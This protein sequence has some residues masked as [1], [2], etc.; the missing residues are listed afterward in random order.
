MSQRA[1]FVDSDV[2][3]NVD[4]GYAYH[5]SESEFLKGFVDL[6]RAAFAQRCLLLMV[7]N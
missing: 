4:A 3:M 6:S 1:I 7:T 5:A 2:V